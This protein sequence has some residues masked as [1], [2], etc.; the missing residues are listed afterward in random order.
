[1]ASGAS[2]SSVHIQQA[3]EKQR[4]DFWGRTNERTRGNVAYVDSKFF[5]S[6]SFLKSI[7]VGKSKIIF[8]PSSMIGVRQYPQLTLQGS[9]CTHVFSEDSYQPR[10]WWPCVKLMSSLWKIAHHWKGAAIENG[11]FY[12]AFVSRVGQL[13]WPVISKGNEMEGHTV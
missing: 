5:L 11:S 9:L 4:L 8:L 2:I 3:C 13:D 7:K 10:S 6:S 12:S 1:M